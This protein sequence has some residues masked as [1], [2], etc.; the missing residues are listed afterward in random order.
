MKKYSLIG[1][2]GTDDFAYYLNRYGEYEKNSPH[3]KEYNHFGD[4]LRVLHTTIRADFDGE[5]RPI[6][7]FISERIA[8]DKDED[9]T[10]GFNTLDE[11]NL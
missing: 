4:A 10:L 3:V 6:H 7:L 2:V 5:T 1:T 8:D 9:L 11:R